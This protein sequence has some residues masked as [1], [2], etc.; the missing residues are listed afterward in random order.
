[1]KQKIKLA[2]SLLLALAC[3]SS[4][5]GLPSVSSSEGVMSDVSETSTNLLDSSIEEDSSLEETQSSSSAE[6]EEVKTFEVYEAQ[7]IP[8]YLNMHNE[9]LVLQ[10]Q[11][12]IVFEEPYAVA[13]HVESNY[14]K[15]LT[16]NGNGYSM[17]FLE[18]SGAY[19][20]ITLHQTDAKI[21]IND[22]T[23]INEKTGGTPNDRKIIYTSINATTVEYNHCTFDGPV[24]FMNNAIC[25]GCTF[26]NEDDHSGIDR[27]MIFF[28]PDDGTAY[29]LLLDECTLSAPVGTYGLLKVY[30]Q[31][32]AGIKVHVKNSTFAE[33]DSWASDMYVDGNV[34]IILEG[35]NVFSGNGSKALKASSE[36]VTVN[37]V[38]IERAVLY[39]AEDLANLA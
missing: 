24:R 22:L 14:V 17:T 6:E 27:Y 4:C 7:D 15:E 26:N 33:N 30:D 2:I 39:T 32:R 28:E 5:N 34:Q 38:A 10:L 12:D 13:S 8:Y 37:G 31:A 23:I 16:I 20:A 36:G 29:T 11:N 1:M 3:F 19:Q 21:I 9:K 35:T 18:T 25:K